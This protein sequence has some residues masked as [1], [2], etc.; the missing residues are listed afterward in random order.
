MVLVCL[1]HL[2]LKELA[3]GLMEGLSRAIIVASI[4]HLSPFTI[5]P[6]ALNVQDGVLTVLQGRRGLKYLLWNC[7]IFRKVLASYIAS[8]GLAYF[9]P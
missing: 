1:E 5:G 4:D 9:K 2:L 6:E 7:K 8:F 3:V